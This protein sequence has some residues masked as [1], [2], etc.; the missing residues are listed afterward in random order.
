MLFSAQELRELV[1][2]DTLNYLN[3]WSEAAEN[4][5]VGTAIHESGMGF[6]LKSGRHLGLYQ[7]SAAS[8]RAVWDHYL[9]HHPELASAVRGL[10]G[11]HSFIANPHKELTTNLRYA[12]AIAWC[13]YQRADSILPDSNDLPGLAHYWRQHF[14]GQRK[15]STADFIRNYRELAGDRKSKAA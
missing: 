6:C 9:V 13:I 1:I 11:Q 8:H 3:T 4:L 2:A 15:G 7:I 12:T 10:A 14:R 5:L